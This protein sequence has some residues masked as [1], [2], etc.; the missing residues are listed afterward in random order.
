MALLAFYVGADNISLIFD[1]IS[2][3]LFQV[4]FCILCRIF[5]YIA[6][7]S[8]YFEYYFV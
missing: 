1:I 8:F 3:S 7:H 4:C 2:R 5:A 6:I